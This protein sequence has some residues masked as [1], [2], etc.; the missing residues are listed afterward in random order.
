ME[1]EKPAKTLIEDKSLKQMIEV[2][3]QYMYNYHSALERDHRQLNNNV[4]Y[5]TADVLDHLEFILHLNR[6]Q[7][8]QSVFDDIRK[9]LYNFR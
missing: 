9:I 8:I 5:R 7:S 6:R 3:Q 1:D 4:A 2:L